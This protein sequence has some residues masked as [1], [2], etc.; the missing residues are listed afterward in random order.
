MALVRW[1]RTLGNSKEWI[2]VKY[3]ELKALTFMNI[4]E[5]QDQIYKVRDEINCL[6]LQDELFWRQ[7]SRAIWLPA[8]DKNK[9][10]FHQRASQ[11]RQKNHIHGFL[12][13]H[14][15]WCTLDVDI[16][17]LAENYFQN[18]FTTSNQTSLES[19]LDSV[20]KVVHPDMN[21]T[22]LQPY[23]PKEV[24]TAL[25]SMHSSKS[26][27]PNGMSP[28]FFQKF[29]HVVGNDATSAVLSTFMPFST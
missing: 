23:T 11:R 15:Q 10:Y 24:R 12:D 16:A 22:L 20:D 3:A 18:L 6:F 27:G 1:G 9:R 26:P 28:F 25:F 19:I 4:A 8:G 29:W 7:Q 17:K 2:E 21:C 13:E 5:N 14:E